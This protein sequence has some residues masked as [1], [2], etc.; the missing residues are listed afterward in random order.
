MYNVG[1][2]RATDHT[3]IDTFARASRHKPRRIADENRPALRQRFHFVNGAGG[4]KSVIWVGNGEI[5]RNQLDLPRPFNEVPHDFA[6]IRLWPN[7]A[8]NADADIFAFRENPTIP[9]QPTKSQRDEQREFRTVKALDDLRGIWN[10]FVRT[11]YVL[12][13]TPALA[14]PGPS[15]DLAVRSIRAKKKPSA[16]GTPVAEIGLDAILVLFDAYGSDSLVY[17]GASADRD[18]CQ[19]LIELGSQ[20]QVSGRPS[21][22]VRAMIGDRPVIEPNPM[23]RTIDEVWE[24]GLKVRESFERERIN[25][26]GAGFVPRKNSL[27]DHGYAVAMFDECGCRSRAAGSGADDQDINGRH[28]WP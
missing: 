26:T 13:G 11:E 21:F 8:T 12:I 14:K 18:I 27:V 17:L 15:G 19:T 22:V 1:G 16:Y 20:G 28:A 23:E 5:G 25:P 9:I 6:D 3:W 2:D 10:V 4:I 7:A 24:L